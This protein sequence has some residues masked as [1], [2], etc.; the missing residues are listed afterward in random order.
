M[1]TGE[2]DMD[3][4]QNSPPNQSNR[5]KG[6]PLPGTSNDP[7]G[8]VITDKPSQGRQDQGSRKDGGSNRDQNRDQGSRTGGGSNDR[9]PNSGSQKDG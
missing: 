2:A 9:G 1:H 3:K 4:E 7:P 6:E 8:Q 5:N